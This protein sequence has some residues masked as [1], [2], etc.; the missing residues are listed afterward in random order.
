MSDSRYIHGTTADEQLRLS[1]LNELLNDSSL[2]AMRLRGDEKILDVGSGL[3]QFSRAMARSGGGIR[4][5]GIE[6]N[7][8]QLA[9]A[10]RQAEL[11]DEAD[12]VEFRSGDALDLPLS[13]HE[14]GTFDIVHARFVLEHLR[15]PE[16]A[17]EAM[18]R[19]VHPGGRVI[20]EDDNHDILRLWPS[21]PSFERMWELY[22]ESYHHLGCDPNIGRRL[23][24]LLTGVGLT[25]T[26]NDILF[27]GSSHGDSMHDAIVTN[28]AGCVESARETLITSGLATSDEIDQAAR[29]L[30]AW[31]QTP[32][33]A[34]WYGT[35]RAEALAAAR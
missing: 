3:G 33:T 17:V 10:K 20:L 29:D 5:V 8:A 24:H 12:L 4:V 32:G 7:A 14:W 34:L 13:D 16:R 9:E 11:E 22:A 1:R 18:A 6:S 25:Q 31:M 2:A 30:M 26:R 27:C 15:E 21:V 28:M 23:V 19:A 35:F